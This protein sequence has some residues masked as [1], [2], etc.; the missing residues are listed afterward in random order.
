MYKYGKNEKSIKS[1]R[2]EKH[3]LEKGK[4]SIG[5]TDSGELDR[6]KAVLEESKAEVQKNRDK[7][8]GLE[9]DFN[10]MKKDP[11]RVKRIREMEFGA[12]VVYGKH[13]GEKQ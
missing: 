6:R 7:L 2:E 9:D 12:E 5:I 4:V 1:Y 13:K 10:K 3:K 8:K 11:V